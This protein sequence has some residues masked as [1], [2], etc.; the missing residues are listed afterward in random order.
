MVKHHFS[1]FRWDGR[2]AEFLCTCGEKQTLHFRDFRK[3]AVFRCR[4]CKRAWGIRC[5]MW[6][7]WIV[8]PFTDEYERT[9][10]RKSNKVKP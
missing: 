5:G 4:K 1:T 7:D 10:Y 3:K 9:P 2:W 6:M 8:T